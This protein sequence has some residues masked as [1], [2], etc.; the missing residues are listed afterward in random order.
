M[1]EF[2]RRA[3]EDGSVDGGKVHGE[4]PGGKGAAAQEKTL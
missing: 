2:G 3:S 4:W 1:S